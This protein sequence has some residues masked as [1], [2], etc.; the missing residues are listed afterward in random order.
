[1]WLS[2]RIALPWIIAL[3]ARRGIFP[4]D[5]FAVSLQAKAFLASKPA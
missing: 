1:M 2:R 3:V 4:P 5:R